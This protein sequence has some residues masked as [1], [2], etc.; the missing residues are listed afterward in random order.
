MVARNHPGRGVV[1]GKGWFFAIKRFFCRELENFSC[2]TK[3]VGGECLLKMLFSAPLFFLGRYTRS[4]AVLSLVLILASTC[5]VHGTGTCG[6][7]R[8]RQEMLFVLDSPRVCSAT[9]K[10]G[11]RA[12]RQHH[13]AG[14]TRP[15]GG[16]S[17]LSPGC[18]H[19]FHDHRER[20]SQL[21]S[22]QHSPA[23]SA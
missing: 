10:C 18:L 7:F 23:P 12:R 8:V 21:L 11:R 2:P 17:Y 15:P 16:K 13:S 22:T 1:E 20:G 14:F 6:Y 3:A 4:Y 19:S 9:T 5:P